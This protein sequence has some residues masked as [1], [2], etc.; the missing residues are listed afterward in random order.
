MD[1]ITYTCFYWCSI[2]LY[3]LSLFYYYVPISDVCCSYTLKCNLME[4]LVPG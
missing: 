4:K 2:V 1:V 3:C